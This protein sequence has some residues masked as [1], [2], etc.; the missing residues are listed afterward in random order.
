[1]VS[2]SDID[3]LACWYSRLLSSSA[4]PS[5]NR[6]YSAMIRTLSSELRISSFKVFLMKRFTSYYGHPVAVPSLPQAFWAA[7][8]PQYIQSRSTDSVS[9]S[10][11][12]SNISLPA[13]LQQRYSVAS[14]RI[15]TCTLAPCPDEARIALAASGIAEDWPACPSNRSRSHWM[16]PA[17]S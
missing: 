17:C 15:T 11:L 1:M 16:N 12:P 14:S 6:M 8:R 3:N 2:C 9:Y 13:Q 4:T 5:R 7:S 10:R